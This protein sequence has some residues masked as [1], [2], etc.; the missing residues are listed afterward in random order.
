MQT[1]LMAS[2]QAPDWAG[3][4]EDVRCPLCEYHL[5]GLAAPQCPECGYA[6]DWPEILDPTR[7]LHPYLYEHH[8]DRSAWSFRKTS[9]HA[10]LPRRFW[11]VLHPAQPSNGRRLARYWVMTSL[12]MALLHGVLVGTGAFARVQTLLVSNRATHA[13]YQGYWQNTKVPEYQRKHDAQFMI[14]HYGSVQA[15]LDTCCPDRFGWRVIWSV[16]AGGQIAGSPSWLG[17]WL[18]VPLILAVWP[19][20]LFAALM[21]FTVSMRRAKVRT[22]HVLRCAIYSGGTL[23]WVAIVAAM[24]LAPDEALRRNGM[25]VPDLGTYA[26]IWLLPVACVIITYSLYVA[27]K[28]YLRF[29][30][31]LAT[32]LA[33][34]FLVVLAAVTIC[35]E[36]V[37]AWY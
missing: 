36:A 30:H 18:L 23:L 20:A 29:D 3:I 37:Y 19:W 32:V 8:P 5:R 7:R 26:L 22:I 10:L 4:T 12:L 14:N 34:Q 25:L 21:I 9:I 28:K 33:S 27:Y 16:L 15:Y 17:I 2:T 35:F 11:R 13:W 6:F 1:E 31:P 24:L